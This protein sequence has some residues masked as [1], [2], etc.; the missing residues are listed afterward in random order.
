[1]R[2][3]VVRGI[4]ELHCFADAPDHLESTAKLC[5][6]A[7]MLED[8]PIPVRILKRLSVPFP[9][10]VERLHR[11]VTQLLQPRH[12]TL[13]FFGVRKVTPEVLPSLATLEMSHFG[14]MTSRNAARAFST[15]SAR[16]AMGSGSV[17]R[18]G[19]PNKSLQ[20]LLVN[21]LAL[22]EVDGPPGVAIEA[23]VEEA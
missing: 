5:G 19:P 6:P 22:V 1:M 4:E 20:C 16:S 3:P 12:G 17:Q 14:R 13:P 15:P 8:H 23:G 10:W 2:A 11:L 21:L 7:R 9:V 18:H